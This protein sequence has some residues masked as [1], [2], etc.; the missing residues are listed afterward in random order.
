MSR[1]IIIGGER[2]VT[3]EYMGLANAVVPVSFGAESSA[4]SIIALINLS[5]TS[6][7]NPSVSSATIGAATA[8]VYPGAGATESPGHPNTGDQGVQWIGATPSGTSGTVNPTF[9]ATAGFTAYVWRVMNLRSLTAVDTASSVIPSTSSPFT[10]NAD[11]Q[12]G[13]AFFGA[14]TIMRDSGTAILTAGVTEDYGGING[15]SRYNVG[16]HALIS[17][18]ETNRALTVDKT[19]APDM[20]G[21]IAAL[22]LR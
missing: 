20:R 13:G 12:K 10:I 19:G 9:S 2:P 18:N 5:A 21:A 17:A 3:V 6:G 14:G 8:T 4:R 7:T 15:G 11:A 22:S 16:G 1:L